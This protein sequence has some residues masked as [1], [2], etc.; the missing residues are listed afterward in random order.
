M[1]KKVSAGVHLLGV[2]SPSSAPRQLSVRQAA[3]VVRLGAMVF[4]L[5]CS[6]PGGGQREVHGVWAKTDQTGRRSDD[7]ERELT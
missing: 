1:M 4:V 6:A 5:S 2:S 7:G 3:A